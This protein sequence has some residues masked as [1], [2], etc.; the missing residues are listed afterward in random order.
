MIAR[1]LTFEYHAQKRVLD[2]IDFEFGKGINIII[3]PNASG[4]STILK[5]LAGVLKTKD[6]VFFEGKEINEHKNLYQKLSYLPQQISVN[7]AL[8]VFEIMLLGN[9]EQLS[10]HIGRKN[11]EQVEKV[12]DEFNIR[13]LAQKKINEIS[14]G[15]LQ[16]VFIAQ[17][18]MKNPKYLLIDEPTNNLDLKNQLE[19][20]DKISRYA[21]KNQ[22]SA[23]I[24]LHD[25]NLAVR[26]ANALHVVKNGKIYASGKPE[27][28]VTESMLEEVYGIKA[29]IIKDG[30]GR[31][32][33]PKASCDSSVL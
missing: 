18:L 7:A 29:K 17:A 14:G 16:E 28:I 24:V 4:K 21:R 6:S 8:N 12:M 33:L 1:Q 27:N 25:L 9:M 3:G 11:L 5:C 13:Y 15:Q 19:I 2:H 26:Y 22:A 20:M 32:I 31:Y 23:L 10:W 30:E